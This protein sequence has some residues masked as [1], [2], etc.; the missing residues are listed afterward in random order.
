MS[1]T[2]RPEIS[3]KNKYSIDRHRY[4]ELK[5]FCLQ[6]PTWKRAYA[7]L[8]G[9]SR[10]PED[11]N[12]FSTNKVGN[13]TERCAMARVTFANKMDMIYQTSM[14]TDPIFGEYILKGV[15]EGYS[16]DYL[17]TKLNIPCCRETYY[18]LYRRFFWLLNQARN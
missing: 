3:T 14:E 18:N 13:P 7:A 8:D 16:Y 12:L 10:R 4:Y 17:K 6:Y 2:V 1:S 15:T 9:L 5:H 11:L